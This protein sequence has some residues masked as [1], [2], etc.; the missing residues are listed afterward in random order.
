MKWSVIILLILSF[1]VSCDPQDNDP[2]DKSLNYTP[3][4]QSVHTAYLPPQKSKEDLRL[5]AIDFSIA[6]I[7]N[8]LKRPE[9]ADFPWLKYNV[10]G[11]PCSSY[12]VSSYVDVENE[13]CEEV[14]LY[15]S[16]DL[17]Y[18]DKWYKN[19]VTINGIEVE[20]YEKNIVKTGNTNTNKDK[21]EDTPNVST[22]PPDLTVWDNGIYAD[23]PKKETYDPPYRMWKSRSGSAIKAKLVEFSKDETEIA[24]KREDGKVFTLKISQLTDFDASQAKKYIAKKK[25]LD[26]T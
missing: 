5:E 10:S 14:R 15:W 21:K 9:T 7:K 23:I 25:R 11:D 6:I 8:H 22:S 4:S 18:D 24:L 16:V 13:Y 1:C 20:S 26:G 3:S 19:T 2:S 17:T 12:I